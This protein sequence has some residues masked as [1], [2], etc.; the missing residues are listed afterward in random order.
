MPSFCFALQSSCDVKSVWEKLIEAKG[1]RQRLESV[2]TFSVVEQHRW[3]EFMSTRIL[4]YRDFYVLPDFAW[5]W[6]DTG[7]KR[8]GGSVGWADASRHTGMTVQLDS[9]RFNQGEVTSRNWES[10]LAL[11]LPETK[12]MEPRLIGC[13]IDLAT[14]TTVV[15]VEV[16]GPRDFRVLRFYLPQGQ[17]VP[18]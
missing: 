15:E 7:D 13:R 17:M 18:K 5:I 9:N 14:G 3:R 8:M 2:S 1:G 11:C 4:D 16:T 12:W 6:Q 10:R